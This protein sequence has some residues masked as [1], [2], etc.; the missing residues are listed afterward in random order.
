MTYCIAIRIETGLIFCSDSRTNAGADKVSIYGKLHQFL[1]HHS[2]RIVLLAAGNLSTS[3]AVIAE[4]RRDIEGDDSKIY[5]TH[6]IREIADYIGEL[7]IKTQQKYTNGREPDFKTEAT[8]ILGGTIEGGEHELYMIYPEGNYITIS[9]QHPFLQIGETKY[10]K[11]ILDR[12]IRKDTLPE[13]AMRCALVSMD[14]TM[15]SNATVGPPIELLYVPADSC[16]EPYYQSFQ[17]DDNYL[18]VLRRSW[19]KNI[20]DAFNNLPAVTKNGGSDLLNT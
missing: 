2:H 1:E 11:P 15:A 16:Q 18:V 12:I 8:F 7:S 19:D 3:Q 10:G 14:S 5:Q 6:D 4:I 17:D 20:Q 13:I 9:G